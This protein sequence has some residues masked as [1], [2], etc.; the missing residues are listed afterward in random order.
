MRF[1]FSFHFDD[2][3]PVKKNRKRANI[4]LYLLTFIR[5]YRANLRL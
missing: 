1:I 5:V 3:Y 2:S 4:K